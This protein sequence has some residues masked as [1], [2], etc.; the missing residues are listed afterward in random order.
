M[1]GSSGSASTFR[2]KEFEPESCRIYNEDHG[3]FAMVGN[4]KL[5]R[6]TTTV[7]KARTLDDCEI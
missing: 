1:T 3:V 2:Y 5:I 7:S 6:D 4:R